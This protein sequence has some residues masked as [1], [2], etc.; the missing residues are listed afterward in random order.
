MKKGIAKTLAGALARGWPRR[1]AVLGC[2]VLLTLAGALSPGG[3]FASGDHWEDG[4]GPSPQRLRPDHSFPKPQPERAFSELKIYGADGSPIRRPIEDWE[5]ARRR[6]AADPEW[7]KWLRA[8]RAEVDEWMAKRRDRLAWVAGWWHDFVSPKDGSFL[9]WTPD[10]PGAE[11]L[12]SPS[13]PKVK[14]TPKIF[15]GWV[16]VFRSQHAGR[17]VDGA[18]LYRLTK[19]RKYAEWVAAQFDFYFRHRWDWPKRR[20]AGTGIR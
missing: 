3:N 6:V 19:E 2:G 18:M 20:S 8:K 10:E 15:G 13:D 11:T 12:F 1:L 9:R 16:F 5:G 4:L 7:Q 14:L 17:M